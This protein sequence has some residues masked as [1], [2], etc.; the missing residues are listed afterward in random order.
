MKQNKTL[1]RCK[2]IIVYLSFI[3]TTFL[4]ASEQNSQKTPD[5]LIQYPSSAPISKVEAV[6]FQIFIKLSAKWSILYLEPKLKLLF[7]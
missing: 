5:Q 4:S 2:I 1:T 3:F 6:I 7:W